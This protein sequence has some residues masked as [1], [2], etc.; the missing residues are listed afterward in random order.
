M[1]KNTK[2]Q[3]AAD[4]ISL[5]YVVKRNKIGHTEVDPFVFLL[6]PSIYYAFSVHKLAIHKRPIWVLYENRE[7]CINSNFA[8]WHLC[9]NFVL[10]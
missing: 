1:V 4:V 7:K 9:V 8:R 3:L 2:I 5:L 6:S 10:I